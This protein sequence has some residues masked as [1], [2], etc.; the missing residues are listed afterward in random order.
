MA[1]KEPPMTDD[2]PSMATPDSPGLFLQRE[3]KKPCLEPDLNDRREFLSLPGEIRNLLYDF[4]FASTRLSSGRRYVHKGKW[5]RIK[6]APHSLA[7]LRTY[8][9][10]YE[11]ARGLWMSQ[12]TFSFKHPDSMPEKLFYRPP[13]VLSQIRHIRSHLAYLD[14][15]VTTE[16]HK[17]WSK[18]FL[19]E[20]EEY[21]LPSAFQLL[22]GLR[23]KTITV[24]GCEFEFYENLDNIFE[25]F[26]DD[27]HWKELRF[28]TPRAGS[29]SPFE[30]RSDIPDRSLKSERALSE[31]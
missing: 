23:L 12:V 5:R 26:I 21:E 11:D 18:R 9:Q 19:Y 31:F 28:I 6:S 8:R 20:V 24:L 4:L 1:H 25:F 22:S 17:K 15:D 29:M 16:A 13:S 7:I 10:M 27:S 3:S 30:V 14:L 2:H